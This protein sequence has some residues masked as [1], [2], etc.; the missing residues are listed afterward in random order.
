MV[1]N[2]IIGTGG[3]MS[4]IHRTA[5]NEKKE[6]KHVNLVGIG[7]PIIN[8]GALENR[9]QKISDIITIDAV[10]VE[11][12]IRFINAIPIILEESEE[13]LHQYIPLVSSG[14]ALDMANNHIA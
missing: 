2:T 8:E 12:N 7:A 9:A 4:Q 6:T 3:D 10:T 5:L 11:N 1:V 13:I 14:S